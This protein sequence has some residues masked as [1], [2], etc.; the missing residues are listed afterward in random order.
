VTPST[1]VAIIGGGLA[2]LAAARLLHAAGID[3]RVFEA[4]D[5]LGGRILSV[6]RDSRPSGDGFDLG[7]SWFWP[8]LQPRMARL[9]ED[10]GLAAFVQRSEGDIVV[11]R[12]SHEP[13][14]R[15]RGYAQQP[16]RSG[17]AAGPG[18]WWPPSP[19]RCRKTGCI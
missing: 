17:S 14:Q 3:F 5:R 9:A 8:G 11:E 16:P 6:D 4:R 1:P 2:G 13:P 12:M 19:R 15:Y 7:P 10:L 18:R